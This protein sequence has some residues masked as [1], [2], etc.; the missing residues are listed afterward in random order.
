MDTPMGE[1]LDTVTLEKGSLTLKKRHMKQGPVAIYLEFSSGKATGTMEMDGEDQ[2][3]SVDLDG[4]LFADGAGSSFAIGC[5]PL[6]DGY[7]HRF[8]QFRCA[9]AE[10]EADAAC[11]WPDRKASQCR[12]ARSKPSKWSCPP[13]MAV[14]TNPQSGS[15]KKRGRR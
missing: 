9:E 14:R 1:M 2:S 11:K 5:L 8:S 13:P 4:P 6:A 10:S 12:P 7:Q 3:I 15:P